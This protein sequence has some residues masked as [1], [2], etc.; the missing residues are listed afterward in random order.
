MSLALLKQESG[1]ELTPAEAELL[2]L[3]IPGAQ[4]RIAQEAC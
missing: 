2:T 3:G 1:S 4:A